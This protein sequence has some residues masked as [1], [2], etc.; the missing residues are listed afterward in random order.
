MCHATDRLAP[1]G[2]KPARTDLLHQSVQQLAF[3]SSIECFDLMRFYFSQRS[4]HRLDHGR[5]R[6]RGRGHNMSP[7]QVHCSVQ[8]S[9]LPQCRQTLG[10]HIVSP[11]F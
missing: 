2:D 11:L 4:G 10:Q 7:E 8:L 9:I 5:R 3:R 1:A 6:D